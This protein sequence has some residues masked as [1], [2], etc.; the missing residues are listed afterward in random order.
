MT[1]DRPILASAEVNIAL[2]EVEFL[3]ELKGVERVAYAPQELGRR[4]PGEEIVRCTLKHNALI[5]VRDKFRYRAYA[6]INR[7]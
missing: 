4:A 5:V 6:R 7:R 3:R 2:E 1:L